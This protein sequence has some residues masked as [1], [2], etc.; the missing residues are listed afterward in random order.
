MKLEITVF[1]Q[2]VSAKPGKGFGG[3]ELLAEGL[4]GVQY[5]GR[6]GGL[7]EAEVSAGTVPELMGK[8]K[9]TVGKMSR[10]DA[11]ELQ[12]RFAPEDLTAAGAMRVMLDGSEIS[13]VFRGIDQMLDH[14]NEKK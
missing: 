12:F 2:A 8:I 13:E 11:R 6:I 9:E 10:K 14:Q 4:L 7:A 3:R 1:K 5:V